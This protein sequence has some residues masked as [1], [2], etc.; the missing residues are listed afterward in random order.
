MKTL[1]KPL[2][3]FAEQDITLLLGEDQ[4][5][6]TEASL[7]HAIELLRSVESGSIIYLNTVQTPRAILAASRNLGLDP[8]DGGLIEVDDD[9]YKLIQIVT[10]A[11]G[12]L[13]RQRKWIDFLL[14]ENNVT[15]V[16]VNSWQFA[17]RNSRC[18]EEAIFLLKELTCG[19]EEDTSKAGS[20]KADPVS[21][22]VYG[23]EPKNKIQAQRTSG[24][25]GKLAALAKKVEC[26]SIHKEFV[27]EQ[28]AVDRQEMI[29][30]YNEIG[31]SPEYAGPVSEIAPR[32]P[33]YK[34]EEKFA[35]FEER[36]HS[37]EAV[38]ESQK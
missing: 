34:A 30:A 14:S 21:V 8:D 36:L 17:G 26:I 15:H 24:I 37:A 20:A 27:N 19:L 3:A 31:A 25:Y 22:I 29:E 38:K 16:I 28:A 7:S 33:N 6:N 10:I 9:Q 12:E 13:H 11:R 1:Y 35:E 18:R 5:M 2:P 32:T 4:A 23:E